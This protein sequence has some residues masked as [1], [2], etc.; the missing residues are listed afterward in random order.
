MKYELYTVSAK[1][2]GE[3]VVLGIAFDE[4]LE[5]YLDLESEE[6]AEIAQRIRS[7]TADLLD[8]ITKGE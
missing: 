2:K 8:Y 3:E 6:L 7:A 4:G 1:I 5:D